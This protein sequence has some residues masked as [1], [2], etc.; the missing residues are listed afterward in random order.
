MINAA[1][2]DEKHYSLIPNSAGGKREKKAY[3]K[4]TK[5]QQFMIRGQ[6]VQEKAL[7]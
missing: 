2:R 6:H 4:T 1:E 7:D 5:I 3:L